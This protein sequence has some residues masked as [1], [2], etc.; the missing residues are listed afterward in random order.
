MPK[1]ER[2]EHFGKDCDQTAK[3][4]RCIRNETG[5]KAFIWEISELHFAQCEIRFK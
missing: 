3:K 5:L 4:V 2:G 1:F